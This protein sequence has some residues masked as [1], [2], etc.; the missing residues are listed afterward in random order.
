MRHRVLHVTEW[1]RVAV[2]DTRHIE[3]IFLITPPAGGRRASKRY[4]PWA[5]FIES[6]PFLHKT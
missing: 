4:S 2:K 5:F 1:G 3:Q 6:L